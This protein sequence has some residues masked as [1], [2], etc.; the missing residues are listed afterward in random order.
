M[1]ALHQISAQANYIAQVLNDYAKD[2]GGQCQVVS[3]MR[4]MWN[5]ASQNSQIPMIYVTW[6]GESPWSSSKNLAALTHRVSRD[7]TVGIKRGRGFTAVRGDT[8]SKTT[9][10]IPFFDVVEDVRDIIRSQLG[11]SEDLGQD[12]IRA[13]E[14]Q[15]GNVIMDGKLITFTTKNDLPPIQNTIDAEITLP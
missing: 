11:I 9:S 5:Q 14:W 1:S 12:D 7:W 3:N 4:D 2:N 6:T 13:K 8:L 15:L 10:T